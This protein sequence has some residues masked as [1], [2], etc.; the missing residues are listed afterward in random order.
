[1]ST[2]D[3]IDGLEEMGFVISKIKGKPY[4]IDRL[5]FGFG[6]YGKI[7]DGSHFDIIT[8]RKTCG[9]ESQKK[10]LKNGS[11]WMG[12]GIRIHE[13]KKELGKIKT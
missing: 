6:I 3:I 11:T 1:M 10:G 12:E 7:S 5:S 8:G 4:V 2:K 9:S 13:G